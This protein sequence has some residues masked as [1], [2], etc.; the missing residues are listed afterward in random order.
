MNYRINFYIYVNYG[1]LFYKYK[2][3]NIVARTVC[4]HDL[5]VR[6]AP[7]FTKMYNKRHSYKH[8]LY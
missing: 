4:S 1:I 2:V 3:H 5:P 8:I 7:L 6:F